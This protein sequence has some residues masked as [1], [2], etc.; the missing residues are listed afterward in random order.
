M[1]D[2]MKTVLCLLENID[3]MKHEGNT[4]THTHTYIYLY[5]T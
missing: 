4:H 1:D 3:F 5:K 2:L